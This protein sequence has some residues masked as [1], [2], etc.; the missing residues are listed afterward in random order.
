M[1]N[2]QTYIRRILNVASPSARISKESLDLLNFLT[3]TLGEALA[4]K[5]FLLAS[6]INYKS[7]PVK[8][9]GHKTLTSRDVQTAVGLVFP[10]ELAK[11]GISE[12]A[13]AV[14]RY[15]S[16]VHLP[17]AKPSARAGLQLSVART[18]HILRK[19]TSFRVSE[20][21]PVYMAAAIE[22]IIYELL[23]LAG[24][25]ATNEKKRTISPLHI[26]QAVIED[27]ELSKLMRTLG[28]LLPGFKNQKSKAKAMVYSTEMA[29][30]V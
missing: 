15:A 25:A 6:P 9:M 3:N 17:N 4:A 10:G 27:E 8:S 30:V 1:E 29:W 18:A 20:T 2:F 11:H 24:L 26:K 23:E 28:V 22:Y 13:K 19:N 21:A 12:S 16:S 7:T 5:T 14:T